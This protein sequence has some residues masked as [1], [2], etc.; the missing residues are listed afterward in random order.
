MR[1]EE[2]IIHIDALPLYKKYTDIYL[3]DDVP[4]AE[5]KEAAR[6]VADR[7]LASLKKEGLVTT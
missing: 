4:E 5:R 1:N 6:N 7:V 2:K 3:M